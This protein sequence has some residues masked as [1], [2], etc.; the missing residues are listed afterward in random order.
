[1]TTRL[2]STAILIAL[3]AGATAHAQDYGSSA[4]GTDYDFI[5]AEDPS[6]FLCLEFKFKGWRE[7]PDKSGDTPLVQQAFVFVSYY[8]DGTSVDMAIDAEF[9]TQAAR[10]REVAH[11]LGGGRVEASSS[12]DA[13]IGDLQEEATARAELDEALTVAG[14][15]QSASE[16][17]LLE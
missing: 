6:A 16:T 9:E 2:F 12:L 1:M 8:K 5:R 4:V 17:G 10:L 7:M 11:R 15:A 13:A 14:E 3:C